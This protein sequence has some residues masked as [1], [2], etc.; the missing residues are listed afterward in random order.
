MASF[1][2]NVDTSPM[3]KSI[4]S[5]RGNVNGV[6]AAVVAM[7]AAV[8]A[9]ERAASKAICDNVDEG[10]LMLVKSQISQKAVA[11]YTEM[12]SKHVVLLQ[13]AKAIDN[14][15]R[16]MENDY[17]MIARRYAKLFGSLN[18]ALE[19]RVKELDRPA[20]QL[21]DIRKRMVFDKLKDDSSMIF[22]ISS[23]AMPAMQTALSGKMKQKTKDT[24]DTM[25][26]SI[27][28]DRTY[29]EKVNSILVKN[30]MDSSSDMRY[31]PVA[32]MVSESLLNQGDSIENIYTAKTDVW[33]NTAPVISEINRVSKDLNWS[34]SGSEEK[35]VIRREFLT[36]C[37]KD[38]AEERIT[39]EII[40][41]FDESVWEDCK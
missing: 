28:E 31:I 13:L 6:T 39:K 35:A 36:M 1:D 5:T 34:S 18:K 33:R 22:N 12:T 11:A 38:Q 2:F 24:I 8:I 7:Q 9:S 3:A 10:F 23:E 21:A 40:R 4:D 16:V 20:M 32:F 30:D 29:S 15:K 25:N 37:E 41:L 14:N 17:N 19:I 27:N 26:E